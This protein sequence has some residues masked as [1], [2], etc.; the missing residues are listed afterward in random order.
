MKKITVFMVLVLFSVFAGVLSAASGK[1]WKTAVV[2][3]ASD[4]QASTRWGKTGVYE[5][6][7][8][9]VAPH[10]G[11][12]KTFHGKPVGFDME[13]LPK[14]KPCRVSGVFL[15]D[16]PRKLVV[17]FNGADFDDQLD[18]EK[19]IVVLEKGVPVTKSWEIPADK[20]KEGTLSLVINVREGA[21][22][23]V[24]SL[25]VETVDG[26]PLQVKAKKRLE[27]V[28]D[29]DLEK[30]VMPF[31]RITPRPAQVSG[32]KAP[33]L[34]LNGTW[35]FSAEDNNTF[36]PIQVPGEWMMQGFK[37]PANKFALYRKKEEIP[38]DWKGKTVRLR[39]DAINSVC[40]VRVNGREIG[41][42]IGGMVPFEMDVTEAVRPGGEN[43]V[44]VFVKSESPSDEFS[45]VS[46][47]ATH[48]VGG[49]LRK[50]TLFAVP[51]VHVASEN[52]WVTLDES[53]KN[54]TLHYDAEVINTNKD[55]R[56]ASL[57]LTLRDKEGKEVASLVKDVSLA[58]GE[59]KPV[60]G[61]LSVPN[62]KLWNSESPYLYTL[63]CEVLKEGKALA[64]HQLN[65]GLRQIV[66]KG[67]QIFVNGKP[68]K[69]MGVCRHEV[70]PL[71]GRSIT[72]ELC[73]RDA[74]LYKEASVNL[75]RT[76]HYPP[77]EEFL[78]AC[79]ELGMFV[80]AEAAFCWVGL[81]SDFWVRNSFYDPQFF[82]PYLQGNLDN[83]AAF[84]NHPSVLFWS[85]AN[86]SAWSN[87]W[88]KVMQ[89]MKRYE[90]TRPIAFHDNY[91]PGSDNPGNQPDIANS[92]Y[93]SENKPEMWSN[94]KRPTWFGEY[95]HLQCYNRVELATDPFIQEDWSRPLQR[96][97]DLMWEQPGCLGGAIW[98][99]IDDVFHLPDGTL[100]GYGHWGPI[101]GWRR[102][103]PEH[104][105]MKMA[106]SPVRIFSV[107]AEAGKPVKLEMQNRQ[108]F[109]NMNETDIV[110]KSNDK[111]GNVKLD[112]APHAKGSLVLPA[113]KAGE[114]ITISFK[115]PS[116][117]E[118]AREVV[119]IPASSEKGKQSQISGKTV[120]LTCQKD[121]KQI[122]SSGSLK[123]ELPVP[124]A[125]SLNGEGGNKMSNIVESYTTVEP[126]SWNLVSAEDKTVKFNG[127]GTVGEGELALTPLEDGRLHVRYQVTL[128]ANVNPRQWGLVF[129]LPRSFD[130]VKWSRDSHWSWYPQDHI[131]RSN[132]Q[133]KA[134]P[135]DR[136]FIEEPGV[137]PDNLWKD[138]SNALG[139]NDF[140]STKANIREAALSDG[141]SSFTVFP[142]PK[143]EKPQHVRAWV[144]G[145]KVRVLVAGFNTGGSDRFFNTHYHVERRPLKKGD[146]I[147]SEFVVG[148]A[149]GK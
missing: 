10:T 33:L 94:E 139:S 34:S 5:Y 93:P 42:H 105:G 47:Y 31:P 134:N 1:D 101:D 113:F 36:K 104:H 75:V 125:L 16:S 7:L 45:C 53:C 144:D 11:V 78:Q 121:E 63:T 118:I 59:T 70:H 80:E 115:S 110:W 38:A 97:V 25:T 129:T 68:V 44:E 137:K 131:G 4:P 8:G 3:D 43:L 12:R 98:S 22:A 127:K 64:S 109:L 85:M 81:Y 20:L 60:Q 35:E 76:S 141:K 29:A 84:R 51:D 14:N 72:S 61:E 2:I 57:K 27:D 74:E 13:G 120:P 124:M 92:H 88:S 147:T 67:N 41:E 116:G 138:Y 32:V 145:E 111:T 37:V 100:C 39:F 91:S 89:V 69:L 62:A 83:L 95:A 119:S 123:M 90:K 79:D 114:N 82:A 19:G 86:E 77:S 56:T 103:K 40:K 122:V 28:T 102:C 142:A 96:M 24:Q 130:T 108:N 146:T 46:Q 126:W 73:R 112:L 50:V 6:S 55:A 107:D 9:E 17:E 140:R 143:A 52:N 58:A 133:A 26:K 49:I 66:Q 54:A 18:H 87:L 132:G 135:S 148:S 23:V 149:S 136:K 65:V 117:Q 106:Y 15:S 30:M 128:A 21:N 99:G 48:Q 71:T